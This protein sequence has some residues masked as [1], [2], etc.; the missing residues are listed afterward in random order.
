VFCVELAQDMNKCWGFSEH[1]N[2]TWGLITV[3]YFLAVCRIV[4]KEKLC[5]MD[6]YSLVGGSNFRWS[7]LPPSSE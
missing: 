4:S 6:L 1:G 2:G 3:P 7:I 5:F